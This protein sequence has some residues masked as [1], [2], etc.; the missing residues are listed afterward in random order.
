MGAYNYVFP[1]KSFA[2]LCNDA[3]ESLTQIHEL[4]ESSNRFMYPI[5]ECVINWPRLPLGPTDSIFNSTLAK[6]VT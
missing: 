5:N 1:C 4:M 3:Y 6:E 2:L